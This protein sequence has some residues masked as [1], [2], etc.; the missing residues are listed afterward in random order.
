VVEDWDRRLA[1]EIYRKQ[2]L[3]DTQLATTARQVV[4]FNAKAKVQ[5]AQGPSSNKKGLAAHAMPFLSESAAEAATDGSARLAPWDVHEDALLALLASQ[6]VPVEAVD[7]V[8]AG[9]KSRIDALALAVGGRE[10]LSKVVKAT[11][12][13]RRADKSVPPLEVQARAAV[14]VLRDLGPL[15][16][17]AGIGDGLDLDALSPDPRGGG[18]PGSRGPYQKKPRVR[19]PSPEPDP[20]PEVVSRSGRLV[21][22]STALLGYK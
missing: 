19:E 11:L 15:F 9:A 2:K 20:G 22:K 21:K 17:H 12:A 13:K 14:A 7:A 5:A 16:G 1:A 10:Q 8:S 6:G 18:G 4:E 3:D